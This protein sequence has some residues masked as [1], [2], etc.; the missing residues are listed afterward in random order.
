[1]S[2]INRTGWWGRVLLRDAGSGVISGLVGGKRF[3]LRHRY[4]SPYFTIYAKQIAAHNVLNDQQSFKPRD[5]EEQH[6]FV[7]VNKQYGVRTGKV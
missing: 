2:D 3:F 7:G 1:M 6:E 5:R 4:A